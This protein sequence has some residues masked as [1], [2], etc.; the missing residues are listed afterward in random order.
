MPSYMNKKAVHQ[1]LPARA[2]QSLISHY[3]LPEIPSEI[4]SNHIIISTHQ[5][6]A[7]TC[8]VNR[9]NDN[10]PAEVKS[11]DLELWC[12]DFIPVSQVLTGINYNAAF[13]LHPS[14]INTHIRRS[15]GDI[16]HSLC[17]IRTSPFFFFHGPF[18]LFSF[19]NPRPTNLHR[20][21][22][23]GFATSFI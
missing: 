21:S 17:A 20:Q 11:P 18:S 10:I 15:A 12:G 2:A 19:S 5:Q 3:S 6:T 23:S 4:P 22:E 9:R 7:D 13:R 8:K 1:H 14:A 16:L